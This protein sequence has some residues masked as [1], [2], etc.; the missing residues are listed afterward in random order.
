MD[1]LYALN[2]PP[3][4]FKKA[5]QGASLS[6]PTGPEEVAPQAHPEKEV[7]QGKHLQDHVEHTAV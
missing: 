2:V 3:R 4:F 5:A 6:H 1:E 7:T